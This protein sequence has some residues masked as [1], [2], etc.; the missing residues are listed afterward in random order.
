M[1]IPHNNKKIQTTN[2]T[3]SLRTL[4]LTQTQTNNKDSIQTTQQTK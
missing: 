2:K 3:N 1:G 4:P